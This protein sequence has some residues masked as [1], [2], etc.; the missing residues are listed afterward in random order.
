MPFNSKNVFWLIGLFGKFK[1]DQLNTY[2]ILF[3][4]YPS[5]YQY[6]PNIWN[7]LIAFLCVQSKTI[8]LFRHIFENINKI[9]RQKWTKYCFFGAVP[10]S[11]LLV[12]N[13][14]LKK[15]LFVLFLKTITVFPSKNVFICLL[16]L[17]ILRVS[18]HPGMT[19][20]FEIT[21]YAYIELGRSQGGSLIFELYCIFMH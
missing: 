9:V 6:N 15:F 11:Y 14:K 20:M 1:V 18:L 8:F 13:W 2:A 12:E 16:F 10:V 3:K 4:D 7:P 17:K 5:Y 21:S 19:S